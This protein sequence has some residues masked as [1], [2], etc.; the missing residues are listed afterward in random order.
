MTFARMIF[1]GCI[2]FV[3]LALA[4]CRGEGKFEERPMGYIG[5]ARRDPFLALGKLLESWDG[6]SHEYVPTLDLMSD[7]FGTVI[8]R[9]E[10][11]DD[12][13]QVEAVRELLRNET[14]VIV[15]M[16]DGEVYINDWTFK[17]WGTSAGEFD[18]FDNTPLAEF[19]AE[20]GLKV[21]DGG[22]S[23]GSSNVRKIRFEGQEYE[24]DMP[25]GWQL[26][27]LED[28]G[29]VELI[30][31]EQQ[32]GGTLPMVSTQ[33]A[34]GRL[35]VLASAKPFRNRFIADHDHAAIFHALWDASEYY[36]TAV[37]KGKGISFFALV[38]ERAWM[39]VVAVA[40]WLA[41]WLWFMM[42]RRAAPMEPLPPA[43]TSYR[44]R[45]ENTASFIWDRGAADTLVA[46][47]KRAVVERWRITTGENIEYPEMPDSE[48]VAGRLAGV[49]SAEKISEAF[50]FSNYKDVQGLQQ[51]IEVLQA[52]HR[53]L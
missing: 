22:Y 46:S 16:S 15:L 43:L 10:T 8:V 17:R 9:R 34:M 39:V 3:L 30:N 4:G 35:T 26:G 50:S 11:L 13:V 49:I 31:S 29:D 51:S 44:E 42:K 24:V 48:A 36:G 12:A 53:D 25:D 33:Y 6:Y 47:I 27:Y 7:D 5:E 19:F 18:E 37:V 45:I 32:D 14:Q 2:G 20:A 41:L 23:F 28:E 38:W 21:Q 1:C 52:I 40:A